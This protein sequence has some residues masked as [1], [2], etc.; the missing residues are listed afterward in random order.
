MDNEIE[1]ILKNIPESITA[2]EVKEQLTKNNNDVTKTITFFWNI[3]EKEEKR[4]ITKMEE[5][6]SICDEYEIEMNKHM[7]K[8]RKNNSNPNV[9]NVSKIYEDELV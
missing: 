3:E 6:R 9:I 2:D 5:V 1:F 4:E 8:L 7:Q